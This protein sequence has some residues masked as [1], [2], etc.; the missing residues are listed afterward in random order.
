MT[1]E[2]KSKINKVVETT[3]HHSWKWFGALVMKPK[4]DANGEIHMAVD[5][6]KLQKLVSLIMAIVLFIIIITYSLVKAEIVDS[7][8][9]D[10]ISSGLYNLFWGT[11][12]M[13]A[14]NMAAGAYFGKKK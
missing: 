12:G 2:T 6:T 7:V 10:P 4:A 11:L 9:I 13:N 5:F 14:V 1:E 3:K 8:A